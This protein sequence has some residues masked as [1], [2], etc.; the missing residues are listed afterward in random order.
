MFSLYLDFDGVKV[1]CLF[2]HSFMDLHYAFS[3]QPFSKLKSYRKC[4]YSK[5][6]VSKSDARLNVVTP[7]RFYAFFQHILIQGEYL[8]IVS[9]S[10]TQIFSLRGFSGQIGLRIRF[11]P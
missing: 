3:Q 2:I 1:G 8:E 5:N 6:Y 9:I 7:T 4:V 11:Q 10:E